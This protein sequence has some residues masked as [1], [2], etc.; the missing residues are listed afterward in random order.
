MTRLSLPARALR[1][2]RRSAA[3][4]EPVPTPTLTLVWEDEFD[5]LPAQLAEP[6]QL[7]VRRRDGLGQRASSSTTPTGRRTRRSTAAGHLVITARAGVRIQGRAYTSARITT[8]GQ[9]GV[10]VR[11]LR[12][13]HQAAAAAAGIW[14]AFWMLGANEPDGRVAR[15]RRDRH[16]GVPRPGA[17]HRCSGTL[18]GPGY[19][20]ARCAVTGSM[21]LDGG[22]LRRRLPHLRRRVDADQH[23]VV[24]RRQDSTT[25]IKPAY[26]RRARGSSTTRSTSS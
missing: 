25:S 13:A 15:S 6:R 23:Q 2:R 18:H 14:P 11:P 1:D 5:G 26:V 20:G 10:Q 9:A 3:C 12:G 21:T 19:S 8:A 4:T 16:H 7:E 24:R 17:E 22:P